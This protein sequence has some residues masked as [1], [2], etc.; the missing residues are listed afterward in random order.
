MELVFNVMSRPLYPWGRDPNTDLI[1]GCLGPR[2]GLDD[3]E[4]RKIFAS[5][6]IRTT[7][8]SAPRQS[9]FRPHCAAW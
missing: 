8:L 1:G 3:L 7:D 9:L 2:K 4:K 6:V 5:M